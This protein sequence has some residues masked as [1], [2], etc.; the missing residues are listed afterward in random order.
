MIIKIGAHKKKFLKK[1]WQVETK[2]KTFLKL[3]KKNLYSYMER[4]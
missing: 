2:K 3:M 4:K 1:I